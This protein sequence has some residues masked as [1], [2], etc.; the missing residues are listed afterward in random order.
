MC[1]TMMPTRVA[2]QL[3]SEHRKRTVPNNGIR[4]AE[5]HIKASKTPKRLET[6]VYSNA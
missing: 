4:V 5:Y 6:S 2:Q 3:A 1:C